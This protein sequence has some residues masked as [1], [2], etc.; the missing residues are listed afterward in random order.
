MGA[1]RS[2]DDPVFRRLAYEVAFSEYAIAL[3]HELDRQGHYIE[4]SAAI[5]AIRETLNR[6]ARR[7]AALYSE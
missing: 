7:G 5:V 2:I 1:V 6:I 3:A 4:P